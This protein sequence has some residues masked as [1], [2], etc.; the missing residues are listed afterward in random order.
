MEK[1]TKTRGPGHPWG[2][3][4]TNWTT[5]VAYN[6]EKWMQGLEKDASGVE[7]RNGNVSNHGIE[8]R[9]THSQYVGRGRRW[10]RRQGTPWLLR[11]TSSGSSSSGGG[12]CNEGSDQSS[13]QSTMMRGSWEGSQAGRAARG[14]KV[15][16][17]LPIFEDEKTK[18]AVS[19]HLWWWDITIFCCLGWDDQHLLLYIFWSLQG[20]PG[21]LVWSL[22]EDATLI[23]V[24]QM[25]YEHYSVV[26]L[27]DALHKELFSLKQG[28]GE[29]VAEFRV[30]L[31]QQVQILQS[32]YQGRIRQECIEEMKQ[33]HLY[34]GQNPKYQHM[35]VHKLDIKH[36][37]C[38][39]DV[40]L[41]AQKLERWAKARK[42]LLWKTTT[43]G[44]SNVTQSQTLG[45]LFPSRK[46]KGNHTFTAWSATV[47]GTEAEEDSGV[48]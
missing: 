19:Y 43:T 14:L 22:G 24:Y 11:D 23:N 33:D 48:K 17:S 44:G 4:K 47:E 25:L 41:A 35:L 5:A 29:N 13:H 7:V 15:K 2:A 16:V 9:N 18:D 6:I 32:E 39:T 45:N 40:L 10:H 3:T 1:R 36:H 30:C 8:W 28:S 38:Y 42:P 21:D 20:F 31:S 26:M 46:L 37:T 34:E 12:S 27:F